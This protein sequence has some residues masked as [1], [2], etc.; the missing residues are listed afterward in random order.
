[1]LGAKQIINQPVLEDQVQQ[2]EEAAGAPDLW[3]D[4]EKAAS[5][6]Q[7]LSEAKQQ[8]ELVRSFQEQLD[9]LKTAL[10]LADLEVRSGCG[11]TDQVLLAS[12]TA[13]ACLHCSGPHWTVGCT[14]RYIWGML[15]NAD[16]GK[17]LPAWHNTWRRFLRPQRQPACSAE[18]GQPDT[19]GR[20]TGGRAVCNSTECRAGQV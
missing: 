14:M 18:P 19:P 13:S 16:Q 3:N 9:D 10:E 20:H 17:P 8:L 12:G 11:Q 6:L 5:V 2:L 7:Q 1:M 4:A 15:P